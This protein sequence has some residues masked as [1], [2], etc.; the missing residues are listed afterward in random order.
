MEAS[1]IP[2]INSNRILEAVA[3]TAGDKSF[4]WTPSNILL[5]I[6]VFILAGFAEIGGGYM[7]WAAIRGRSV[8][9]NDSDKNS[10]S[11]VLQ[12]SPWWFALIGSLILVAYG[13]IPCLQPTDSFGRIYAVYGGF[14][15]LLSFAFGWVLDGDK[16]DLGDIVGTVITMAGVCII[17]FWPRNN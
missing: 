12:R 16:P 7:V 4:V 15:I 1:Q 11:T 5:S 13:F 8:P 6:S 2:P 9:S 14:F 17:M 3:E 10:S